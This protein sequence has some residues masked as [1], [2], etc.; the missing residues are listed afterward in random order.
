MAQ[1]VLVPSSRLLIPLGDLDPAEAAPLGDAGLTPYHA[2]KRSLP[3][4]VPGSTAVVIGLGGLGHM[5]VQILRALTPA[6]IVAVDV[7]A[8]KLALAAEL[9]ADEAVEAGVEAAERIRGLTGGKG[10]DLVLDLVGSDDTLALAAQVGRALGHLTLVGLAMGTLPLS[11]FTL[12]Y[13]C[14]LATTYWG[15]VPELGEVIALAREG[16][17]RTHVERFSLD[18]VASAYERMRAGELRG[19]A[20]VVP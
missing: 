11:F 14:S 1:Y 13:E 7:A 18:D 4:L 6:R 12:P 9:G 16:R 17:I 19:R 2:V 8:D 10:A 15:S 3:L 20:V 5:A